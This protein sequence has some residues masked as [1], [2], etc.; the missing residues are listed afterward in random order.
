LF[1]TFK[2]FNRFAPF[3][4]LRKETDKTRFH[5]FRNAWSATLSLLALLRTPI[6]SLK[7]HAVIEHLPLGAKVSK[8]DL[9]LFPLTGDSPGRNVSMKHNYPDYRQCYFFRRQ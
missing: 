6:V 5:F 9:N 2:P 1:K 8:A 7:F 4:P 3:K